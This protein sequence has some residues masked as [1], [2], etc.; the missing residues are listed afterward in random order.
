MKVSQSIVVGVSSVLVGAMLFSGCSTKDPRSE[1]IEN[2]SK[3]YNELPE[4]ILKDDSSFTAVGSVINKGQS[5]YHLRNEAVTL[6]K[7]TLVQKISAKVDSMNK[8]YFGS[9]GATKDSVMQDVFKSSS[10]HVSSQVLN[11]V[12]VTKTYASQDGELF[13]QVTL[14]PEAFEQF[15]KQNY[16]SQAY[17]YQQLQADKE[18]KELKEEVSKLPQNQTH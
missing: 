5:F 3:K 10:L 17:L 18:W 8:T 6:A 9:A 4:W 2:F 1:R 11:G 16:K 15:L 14:S 13:V 12:Q 7:A